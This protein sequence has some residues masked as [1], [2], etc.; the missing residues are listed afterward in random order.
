M[1]SLL[2][3]AQINRMAASDFSQAFGRVFE[4]S[5]W[6]AERA[7]ARRPFASIEALHAAMCAVVREASADEQLALL[8]AHPALAG[9]EAIAGELTPESTREQASAGLNALSRAEMERISQLNAAHAERFGF[10]F[11]IAVRLNT[12]DRILAEFERRLGLD[13]EAERI[14]CLE[15]VYLITGLR[16]R[17]LVSDAAP[18]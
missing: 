14:A 4:H 6:I 11:I 12:R 5:P 17:D 2:T 3:L 13:L 16:L 1:T 7:L 10:P 15:Q 18:A 9:R 8:R